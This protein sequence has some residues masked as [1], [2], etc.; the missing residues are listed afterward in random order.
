[1]VNSTEGWIVGEEGPILKMTY[2][3]T[4]VMDLSA[5]CGVV[6]FQVDEGVIEDLAS[7]QVE[8]MPLEGKPQVISSAT[9]SPSTS[10]VSLW[11]RRSASP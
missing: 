9:C 11:G 3:G 7:V 4:Q 2:V 6:I 8:A 5:P 1:M 10:L